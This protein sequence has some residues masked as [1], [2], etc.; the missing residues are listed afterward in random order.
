MG[1]PN[2]PGFRPDRADLARGPDAGRLGAR[3]ALL[4]TVDAQRRAIDRPRRRADRRPR[5]RPPPRRR[6]LAS[7]RCRDAFDLDREDPRLRDRYGR[8]LIGQ[9]L[10]LARRLVE[11]GVP[12]VQVNLG[13]SNDWD[14]H[15]NNFER[16]K[17]SLLPPFDRAVSA[18]IDDLDAR[19]ALGRRARDRDRRVRPDAADRV[20]ATKDGAGA[21]PD[22]RDHWAGVFTLLAFGAGVGRG[23]VLGA[24][25]RL[26]SH[27]ASAAYSP[28]DLGAS[29]LA[30]LGVDPRAEVHDRLGG[31]S[32]STSGRRS[33]GVEPNLKGGVEG[34]DVSSRFLS[35]YRRWESNPHVDSLRRSS[36]PES[37]SQ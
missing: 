3:S 37:K 21:T 30:A 8:H 14:T 17:D 26:A 9:G 4:A 28:A 33:R 5:P 27:P 13:E 2:E 32:R 19:A 10:L 16:L 25:D 35:P 11:A 31:R 36:S 34:F 23:Q 24:S 1:D 29:I 22:G 7:R 12:L 6:L 15:A 18:L 20:V